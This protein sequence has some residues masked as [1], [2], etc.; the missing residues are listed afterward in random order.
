MPDIS[1][2]VTDD[3]LDDVTWTSAENLTDLARQ[4]VDAVDE[5]ARKRSKRY[6]VVYSVRPLDDDEL[7]SIDAY[8]NEHIE[9]TEEQEFAESLQTDIKVLVDDQMM[10]GTIQVG[11]DPIIENV[12][13]ESLIAGIK[14]VRG[15]TVIDGSLKRRL[16]DLRYTMHS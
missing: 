6:T 7:A 3:S 14:I 2:E 12:I 16:E 13:D 8:L 1:P 9:E 4:L 11:D 15:D 10:E 5:A